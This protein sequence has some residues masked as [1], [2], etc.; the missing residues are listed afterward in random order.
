MVQL[1]DDPE[2]NIHGT[3]E[4]LQSSS[5]DT[6]ENALDTTAE[7][8]NPSETWKWD[9]D[10][11]NPYNWPTSQKVLQVAMIGWSAFTTLVIP[12][13]VPRNVKMT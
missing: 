5:E 11:S 7:K 1:E 6:L 10:P 9:D 8:P 4:V 13:I 12:S 3:V 2:A